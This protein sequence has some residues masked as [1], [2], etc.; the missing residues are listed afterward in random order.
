MI[1]IAPRPSG[2][3]PLGI[4]NLDPD[5]IRRLGRTGKDCYAAI[6][7]RD[8]SGLG[9]AMNEC[10]QCWEAVLP[11]TVR[12]PTIQ[13]D[14]MAILAYYQTRYAGAMY[15]GCGGGYLFVASEEP[16]AGA[17]RVKIRLS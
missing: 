16:V 3:G 2:Y 13:I 6:L 10:M 7:A 1:P 12:H 9:S 11:H 17:A 5:W 15:S 8:L 14:L 4:K